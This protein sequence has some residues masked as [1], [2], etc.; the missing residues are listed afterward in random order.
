MSV[1]WDTVYIIDSKRLIFWR[2]LHV[3]ENPVFWTLVNVNYNNSVAIASKY[4]LDNYSMDVK[5][6][7]LSGEVLAD[8]FV[9]VNMFRLVCCVMHSLTVI[10]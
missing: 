6:S 2:S 10:L 3:S 1:F 5:C 8:L 7:L 9:R 4:G